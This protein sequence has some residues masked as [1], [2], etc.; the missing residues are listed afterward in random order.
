MK[1]PKRYNKTIW[2]A[3]RAALLILANLLSASPARSHPHV[4][5]EIRSALRFESGALTAIDFDW[6]F[7]P[8]FTSQVLDLVGKPKAPFTSEISSKIKRVAFDNLKDYGYFLHAR[9]GSVPA[10]VRQVQNFQADMIGKA[11]QYRFTV[12]L[13]QPLDPRAGEIEIALYDDTYFI[14]VGF[15]EPM[16]TSFRLIDP[17][18]GC[19]GEAIED[20]KATIYYGLVHPM[21]I[22]VTCTK[23]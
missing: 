7:D 8:I 15:A 6:R 16:A 18:Q 2:L 19:A 23:G 10:T 20:K 1:S 14:D 12:A 13:S 5:I 3:S 22:F 17:P 21:V 9:G 4:W 11:L